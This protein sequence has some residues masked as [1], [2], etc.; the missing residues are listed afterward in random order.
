MFGQTI[1]KV[2]LPSE[3][4][5]GDSSRYLSN[6]S[7]STPQPADRLITSK[8]RDSKVVWPEKFLLGFYKA[9]LTIQAS[10]KEPAVTE[11][12]N[13]TAFPFNA[14]IE[15]IIAVVLLSI[16]YRRVKRKMAE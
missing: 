16:I 2:D 15:F 9:R 11:T 7:L 14:A 12:I 1:G 6:Q 4:I 3:N 10:D 5:L 8:I 13:F